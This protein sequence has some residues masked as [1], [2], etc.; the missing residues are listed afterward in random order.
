[1]VSE[2]LGDYFRP[3]SKLQPPIQARHH[4]SSIACAISSGFLV[5]TVLRRRYAAGV[6][7]ENQAVDGPS[8]MGRPS[9]MSRWIF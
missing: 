5:G 4:A 1:M 7:G 3:T 9:A 8:G 2:S 6:Y